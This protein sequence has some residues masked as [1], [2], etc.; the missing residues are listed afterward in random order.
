MK[1]KIGVQIGIEALPIYQHDSD[2]GADIYANENTILSP[3]EWKAISTGLFLDIPRGYEVQIRPR[4]GMAFKYG[5]TVL[6]SPGTIDSGYQ[7][8]VKVIL[9][10]HSGK[11]FEINKGDRI[12]QMIVAEVNQAEFELFSEYEESE[13]GLGGFGSSGK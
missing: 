6:N 1:I 13:R 8:E 5:V 7:N 12:A 4:S 10:N 2:A 3:G 9:I 11:E